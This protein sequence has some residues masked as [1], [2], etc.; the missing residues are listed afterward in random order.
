MEE[1]GESQKKALDKLN[2]E[3][4]QFRDRVQS[5]C[6]IS[7]VKVEGTD[8]RE[9]AKKEFKKGDVVNKKFSMSSAGVGCE[10]AYARSAQHRTVYLTDSDGGA[11]EGGVFKVSSTTIRNEAKEIR[12][13]RI[14]QMAGLKSSKLSQTTWR[15]SETVREKNVRRY[16]QKSSSSGFQELVLSNGVILKGT[17][18]N[19][20][21][22]SYVY[23]GNE[24]TD[25]LSENIH[26]TKIATPRGNIWVTYIY[27]NSQRVG[28]YLNGQK[29]SDEEAAKV[30]L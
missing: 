17:T 5:S 13:V 28:V 10:Y 16:T 9:D 22:Y 15:D 23:N 18:Q 11:S 26:Q 25:E 21:T 24:V 20:Y 29:L 14:A 30:G 1:G 8:S 7:G 12:N 27:K 3:G 2:S 19:A 4:R 6:Q